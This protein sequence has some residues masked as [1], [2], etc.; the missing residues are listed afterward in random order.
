MFLIC[1]T[2]PGDTKTLSDTI[3]TSAEDAIEKAA[4]VGGQFKENFDQFFQLIVDNRGNILWNLF[5]IVL[6]VIFARLTLSLVSAFTK[7]IMSKEKYQITTSQGKRIHTLLSLL[8]STVRYVVY[9][10]AFL[11]I[12]SLLG[13]GKPLGNILVT[14]G[15]GSLA[16][17]FGAQN[18]VRDVVT[19]FFMIF[20]NQFAV[21]D[22]IK[23]DDAEGTVE[24]TAMR[25][26]YLRSLKGD[27]IIIPNG[28]ITRVVNYTRGGYVASIVIS[29][30][31]EANT[32]KVID[33]IDRAVQ[34]Y[35]QSHPD[36]IVE[37]PVVLGVGSLNSSSVDINVSC[38]VRPMKQWEV[39]RGMRLAVKEMFDLN[40]IEFPYPH[41]VTVPYTPHKEVVSYED[42]FTQPT[43]EPVDFPDWANAGEDIEDD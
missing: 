25:V 43:E 40:E 35:A 34:Q 2:I 16:I 9:F 11:M 36:L 20:E 31:Y 27:Q 24:A 18:L 33:F 30:A 4:T 21:G 10:I 22:Y 26:T 14:A 19:G 17:G 38:K 15:I 5:L 32:R 6:I 3:S 41:M 8:R 12:I 7:S 37:P 29:T 42:I 39:E 23:I 13:F 1:A 28:T